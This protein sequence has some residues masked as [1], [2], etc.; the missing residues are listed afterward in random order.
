MSSERMWT[1]TSWTDRWPSWSRDTKVAGGIV[2]AFIGFHGIVHVLL[3]PDGHLQ[4]SLHDVGVVLWSLM[5]LVALGGLV[6]FGRAY[7]SLASHLDTEPQVDVGILPEDERCILESV[8]D[9]P[10]ITQVEVVAKSDFSD[11]KVSQTLK[12]LRERGLVYREPQ[13]R[14]YRLYPGSIFSETQTSPE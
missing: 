11:A 3:A 12:A 14:T 6:V 8:L 2:A 1:T 13:G 5:T 9:T 7:A 10:G 4:V